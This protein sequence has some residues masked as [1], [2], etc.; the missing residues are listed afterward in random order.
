MDEEQKSLLKAGKDKLR[1]AKMLFNEEEHGESVS[2]AYY[3]MFHAARALLLE[4]GSKPRT[5]QGVI[6][7][8]GKLFRDSIDPELIS[9]MSQI[10]SL[11]EDADYE[12]YFDI[13]RQRAG[14]VIDTARK[15][16][17]A[18]EKILG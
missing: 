11:R 17:N 13:S 14:E 15:F 3:G 1:V 8:L 18:V 5:H 16:L 2:R 7:E 9:S 6:T 4:K 12:P 10:Q